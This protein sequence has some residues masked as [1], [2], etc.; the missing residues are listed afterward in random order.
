MH[1][2]VPFLPTL[3]VM[4]N[5]LVYEREKRL[6]TMMSMHGLTDGPYWLVAY[7]YFFLL[8]VTFVLIFLA[9][10]AAFGT[11]SKQCSQ[12]LVGQLIWWLV[13]DAVVCLAYASFPSLTCV[14]NLLA[15]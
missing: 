6:R 7:A 10:G 12:C 2:S 15:S 9:S 4:V 14:F 1:L 3:Q 11:F 8:S 13:S 5:S